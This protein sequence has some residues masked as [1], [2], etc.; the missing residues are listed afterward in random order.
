ME[1]YIELKLN[2]ALVYLTQR[3]LQ[4]LLQKDLELY[5]RALKRGKYAKRAQR[6][7]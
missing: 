4:G 2:K 1:D 7:E 6:F 5:Q 3:E